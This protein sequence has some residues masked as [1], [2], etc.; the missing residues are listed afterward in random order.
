MIVYWLVPYNMMMGYD[1]IMV[2]LPISFFGI[3][4]Y[5]CGIFTI[6]FR[7]IH[8]L[9]IRENYQ[10]SVSENGVVL[11]CFDCGWM[12]FTKK[13]SYQLD[14]DFNVSRS[15]LCTEYIEYPS[16]KKRV[17]T[18]A[19]HELRCQT[20]GARKWYDR[21]KGLQNTMGLI[22]FIASLGQNEGNLLKLH[23][24]YCS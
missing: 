19:I 21:R 10:I 14:L 2:D 24:S 8:Q 22:C 16:K 11:T 3:Q 15:P 20:A 6:S 4:T 9:W 18:G 13:L 1:G 5:N 12:G 7:L 23:A 17:C